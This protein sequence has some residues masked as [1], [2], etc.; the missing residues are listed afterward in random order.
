MSSRMSESEPLW[1][2]CL[3]QRRRW[4]ES[5]PVWVEAYL[6]QQPALRAD[7]EAVLDLIYNE[8]V[9]REERGEQPGLEEYLRRFPQFE[10]ELRRQ[11]ALHGILEEPSL[12]KIDSGRDSSAA[13]RF[14]VLEDRVAAATAI[15]GYTILA[16][17]GRGG[18]GVVYKAWQV[19][20]NRLVAVKMIL[21]GGHAGA[22]AIARFQTEAEAA[23]RLQHPHIVQIHEIGEHNGLPYFSLELI[24]GVGLD[25]R[26]AGRAQ[27]ATEA[28]RLVEILARTMHYAH[29]QGI[30]HRDLKPSNV[31]L[32]KDTLLW[33][34]QKSP[35]AGSG[36]HAAAPGAP[37]P[38]TAPGCHAR[39]SVPGSG[40][41][42]MAP[43][44]R[45]PRALAREE[46]DA[47]AALPLSSFVPKIT[48]FGLAKLR[49]L[50]GNW[51][52]SEA[53]IG[54][55]NYMAPE[56]ASGK[57]GTVGP[58]ADVYS[59]GAI[60]YELLTGQPP[61]QGRTALDVLHQVQTQEPLSPSRLQAHVPPDLETICL[62]CL[63][64]QPGKRYA[65]AHDLAEDLRRF[66]NDEPILA[67]R[68]SAWERVRK[69]TRRRPATATLVAGTVGLLLA[70]LLLVPWYGRISD[71]AARQRAL[72]KYQR[73]FQLHDAV[74]FH[75]Q[76]TQTLF[77]ETLSAGKASAGDLRLVENNAREALALVAR[78]ARPGSPLALDQVFDDR[79]RAEIA[80]GCYTLHL[81][82]AEV[83]V[84]TPRPEQAAVER[85]REG[86]RILARATGLGPPTRAYHL[87]RAHYLEQLGDR[88]A[89]QSEH[90]QAGRLPPRT[91]L[92]YFLI[93]YERYEQGDVHQ[94]KGAFDRALARE[95]GHFWAG[96]YLALCHL[97][98][99]NWEAAK[100]CLTTC[101]GQ[102]AEFVWPYVLRG[103]ANARLNEFESALAD[104]GRAMERKPDEDAL[105][106]LHVNRGL[107]RLQEGQLAAA[108]GDL[109]RALALE[110]AQYN[111]YVNL[112]H[113]Y[114]RQQRHE[115]AIAQLEQ[116]IRLQPPERILAEC[117]AEQARNLYLA[118]K[119]E[120]ALQACAAALRIRPRQA[121][122][123]GF[124]GLAL[125]ELKRY[126]QAARAFDEYLKQG[127]EPI[128]D[129]FRGRG[130]ARVK[131]GNYLGARDDYT[132]ALEFKP[133]ADL[134]THRGW[135]YV[136]ADAW[137]PALSD[138]E[139][140]LRLSPRSSEAYIGR[141]LAR[142]MLGSYARA[143]EDAEVAVGLAPDSPEMMHNIACIYA[144]A[145]GTVDRDP[146]QQQGQALASRY[147]AR[148][149]QAIRAAL[150]KL[151]AEERKLFWQEKMSPDTA[152]DPIRDSLEFRQLEKEFGASGP[153]AVK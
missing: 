78:E 126:E 85:Y 99:Q 70:L 13:S 145:A 69:W 38:V 124:R 106:C 16:E 86:L 121:V 140:A 79:Q 44:P 53:F 152:L 49:D 112:A 42:A 47:F 46:G 92:D 135:A 105:Y 35:G 62:K 125:L 107:M 6:E 68:T 153:G 27:P 23:A 25:N 8:I 100:A 66:L 89:A 96:Y 30:I 101:L 102:Q 21:G 136:F 131:Q 119:Y 82:L 19:G 10:A 41:G 80:A 74:L 111:A 129:I 51:S 88:V 141:G 137:K 148:A 65:S 17:L 60:L 94:A 146:A 7:A 43:E 59:L 12:T 110:P 63:E 37:D 147:R 18:M 28:A 55:P 104:F 87:R 2:V 22:T 56:Q 95:P 127:G 72:E 52:P 90:E 31:L 61:F 48:D 113:V 120:A 76:Q 143:V 97:Q 67:R 40:D 45:A 93:G 81:V 33:N 150:A 116:A 39:E 133:D 108:A 29:R 75:G 123:L 20:L 3:N 149:G 73:F 138:F 71:Q 109:Q 115:E 117:H 9:L 24:D 98:A 134:H 130:L 1:W 14:F 26:L 50:E 15:P 84:Q 32:Q 54:T 139:N 64:K 91:A 11:F 36:E 77:Q 128:A 142:V 151:P 58:P 4:H 122:V 5:E 144:Q 83:V 57:T 132:R 103:I 34:D 114:Q 118:G